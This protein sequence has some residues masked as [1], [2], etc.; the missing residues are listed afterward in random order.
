M[1][2]RKEKKFRLTNYDSNLLKSKL[3]LQGM[4]PL[5]AKREVNSLYYDTN[6][7]H[8]YHDSEEGLLP[9]R[10]IR[11]RW[12]SNIE[13]ANIEVKISS[14]E[15]RFKTSDFIHVKSENT[16]PRTLNDPQYGVIFS[17]LRVSYTREYFMFKGMRI[18]FDSDIKYVNYR[19]AP[20]IPFKDDECVV[21]IKTGINVP[22][23]HIESLMP[24]PISRFSKYSRG[25]LI[26]NGDL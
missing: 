26:M 23:D 9:R 5:Y 19:R 8:M 3:L 17:S 10:K 15:G 2:F 12:Y 14:L 4:E 11:I 7:Y 24:F 22:D 16:A 13:K 18:T 6:L 1:T 25:L 20:N 21:E